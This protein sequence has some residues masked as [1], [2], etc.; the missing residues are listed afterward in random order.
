MGL[1]RLRERPSSSDTNSGVLGGK[2]VS[3]LEG[4][5][6]NLL[7]PIFETTFFPAMALKLI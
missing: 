4:L 2:L 5:S 7:N 3:E 1:R 6:L